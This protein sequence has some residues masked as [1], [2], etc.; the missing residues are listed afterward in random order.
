MPSPTI[1]DMLSRT[2]AV[3]KKQWIKKPK[4]ERAAG[5]AK[6]F[7]PRSGRRTSISNDLIEE[8]ATAV[9]AEVRRKKSRLYEKSRGRMED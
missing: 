7:A 8:P 2:N 1:V 5:S 4:A 3:A 9:G 6:E